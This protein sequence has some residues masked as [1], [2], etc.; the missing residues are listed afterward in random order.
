MGGPPASQTNLSLSG[1]QGGRQVW[2]V[3]HPSRPSR[4]KRQY[5]LKRPSLSETGAGPATP[6][7]CPHRSPP[8]PGASSWGLTAPQ[9]ASA[10]RGFQ[11]PA[12]HSGFYSGI[13]LFNLGSYSRMLRFD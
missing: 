2:D 13:L 4:R 7:H 9:R 10:Q 11:G 8:S 12:V 3:L 6:P 1:V 5:A